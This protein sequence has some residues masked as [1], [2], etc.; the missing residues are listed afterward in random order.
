MVTEQ[1]PRTI[2]ARIHEDALERVPGFF[3]AT[4]RD[5]LNELLQNAGGP[6]RPARD[7]HQRRTRDHRRRRPGHRQPG[8]RAVLRRDG[9]GQQR[10]SA[11]APR[12]HGLLRPSQKPGG[13]GRLQNG[14]KPTLAG[15]TDPRPLHR[16][17]RRGRR[18]GRRLRRASPRDLHHVPAQGNPR[19]EIEAAT[20]YYPR[21]SC[22]TAKRCSAVTSCNTPPT[23][24]PG[25]AYASG[26]TSAPP[27]HGDHRPQL[28]RHHHI[29]REA[30]EGKEPRPPLVHLNRRHRPA[31]ASSSR[32]QPG[33]NWVETKFTEGPPERLPEGHVKGHANPQGRRLKGPPKDGPEEG[34]ELPTRGPALTPWQPRDAENQGRRDPTE[35]VEV[36]PHAIVVSHTTMTRQTSRA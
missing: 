2:R 34:I 32:S 1:M 12:R 24:R 29:R 16:P 28:P 20:A 19:Q 36:T 10:G 9:V 26:C 17:A 31:R 7:H 33:R 5:I 21:R 4:V 25:T 14:G 13:P 15:H 8:D 3:N 6:A 30:A 27:S 22:S 35:K 23:R 18:R 11:G